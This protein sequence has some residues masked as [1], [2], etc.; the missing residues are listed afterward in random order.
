MDKNQKKTESRIKNQEMKDPKNKK[1]KINQI[2][3]KILA[4]HNIKV[5]GSMI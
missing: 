4:N 1:A 2:K 5:R 3:S